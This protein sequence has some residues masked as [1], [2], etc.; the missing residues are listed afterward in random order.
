MSGAKFTKLS[1]KYSGFIFTAALLIAIAVAYLLSHKKKITLPYHE[2]FSLTEKL[3]FLNLNDTVEYVGIEACKK[4]HEDMYNAYMQTGMGMSWGLSDLKKSALAGKLGMLLYDEVNNLYYQP[5]WKENQLFIKEFRIESG[6]TIFLRTEKLN[7]IVGSGQHTN[8]HLISFN[9]YLHQVP[10][11]F[12][13][14]KQYLD[15][16]PGFEGMANSRFSRII[17]AE[18]ISCHNSYP[19]QVDGSINK[20][21]EIPLG[22]NC[23][24]C[25]GPGELHVKAMEAGFIVNTLK[26]ADYTIVN[27]KRLP[28]DLLDELCSRCH[29]QGNSVLKEGR[30][31]YDFKPG[32]KVSDVL[33]VFREQY[34]NDDDAFWM[35]T[36]SERLRKSK[37]FI[38]SRNN[39]D[40]KPLS[41]IDCHFTSS[42]KHVGSRQTPIDTFRQK[43]LNCHHEGTVQCKEN[44]GNRN[45]VGDNCMT[46]HLV[47]TGVFDIPH[48]VISDHYIRVTDKWKIP[49]KSTSEIE[50]GAFLGLKC[51]SSS[52]VEPIIK[53]R[54]FLYH[55]EKFKKDISLL[56][57][58]YLY[59]TQYKKEEVIKYL[60][61]YYYL[62]NDFSSVTKLVERNKSFKADA[63]C[64]YQIGQSYYNLGNNNETVKYYKMAVKLEPFNLDYR[65]KL[66]TAYIVLQDFEQAMKEFDFIIKENPK[67]S[68]A[69]NNRGF[70]YLLSKDYKNAEKQFNSAIKLDPDYLNAHIN[71]VKVYIAQGKSM[72]ARF[73]LEKIK[74]SYPS[75]RTIMELEK[76]MSY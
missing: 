50:T 47:K 22:I 14:Q 67:V 23:E 20:Y 34:E 70:I 38:K 36:H 7:Y 29:N 51:M 64:Y 71:L 58:A 5:F 45:S 46:C 6:D 63:T 16:P 57:S 69:Y 59:L 44:F 15:F 52:K 61:Y 41:C 33:D 48:V 11:T 39:P 10:F 28:H 60:I 74:K 73:Y 30:S 8:S 4:C 25:H 65:N 18:C 72:L 9:G 26:E 66:G 2:G 53:A 32:M 1:K 43:C 3:G 55:Y 76:L 17:G 12:Y 75:E 68:Q 27:P 19:K 13:T 62:K 54:A 40:V 24:R 56:D 42:M 49:V 21:S 31:F 37:C 35:E